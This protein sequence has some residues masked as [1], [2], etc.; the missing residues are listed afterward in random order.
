MKKKYSIKKPSS[1]ICAPGVEGNIISYTDK[2][3]KK[4]KRKRF[5]CLDHKSLMKIR[6]TNGNEYLKMHLISKFGAFN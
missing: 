1:G 6:Y 5:T 2:K 4:V 3:T